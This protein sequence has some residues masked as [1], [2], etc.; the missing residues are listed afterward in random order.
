MCAELSF[1]EAQPGLVE[2]TRGDL[3]GLIRPQLQNAE[4]CR[5]E[6][7]PA[8]RLCHLPLQPFAKQLPG[9]GTQ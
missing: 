5:R 9:P 4:L 7:G 1:Q 6:Q 2:A 3:M 8:R